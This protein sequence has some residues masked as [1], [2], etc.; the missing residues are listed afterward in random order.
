M[1]ENVVIVAAGR[2]AI[3]GF[4]GTLSSVPAPA[5]G[6]TVIKALLA[7]T[8]IPAEKIDEVIPP[9]IEKQKECEIFVKSPNLLHLPA[10][11][12]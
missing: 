2:T 8:G 5:L 7:R 9:L 11:I 10:K 12:A 1:A 4:G 6:A 3:G